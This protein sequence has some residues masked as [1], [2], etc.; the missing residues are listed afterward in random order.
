MVAG[1]FDAPSDSEWSAFWRTPWPARL[2][3][4]AVVVAA[5]AVT[6]GAGALGRVGGR[7][8]AMLAALAGAGMANVELGRLAEGRRVERQRIH[9][10]LSAWPFAAALLLGPGLAGWVAILVYV[11]ARV[12]GMRITL[13]KWVGSC[14]I[15]VLAALA[16]CLTLEALT[17]GSLAAS[18]SPGDLAGVVAAAAAFLA[19]ETALLFAISRLN[20]EADE[21]YLRA[22]LASSGFYLVEL[23]VLASGALAAVLFRYEPAFLVLAGPAYVLIQRGLL[24]QPLQHQARHDAKTGL[25]NSEAWRAAASS[26]LCQ[27]RREGRQLAVLI[28]DVD[29]FK[30]VNDTHGHLVGDEVLTRAANAIVTCVRRTDVVGRFGGDEFCAVLECSTFDEAGAAGERVCS[31]I[32]QLVFADPTLRITASVGVA[33]TDPADT[34]IDLPGLIA[35]ADQALYQAKTAGRDQVCVR[36]A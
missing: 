25:L 10:G 17:G 15:V 31:E 7:E 32:G 14:A 11:H 6:L 27:A 1:V 19:V 26:A 23:A 20:L 3:N 33:I 24:H 21:V 30:V 12:R 35:T 36:A 29:H 8:L 28:V 13:W 2:Y 18:G 5:L 22:M 9:K 16:A 34:G 4:A